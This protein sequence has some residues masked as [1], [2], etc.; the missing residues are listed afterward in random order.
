MLRDNQKTYPRCVVY[1]KMIIINQYDV[2]QQPKT[3]NRDHDNYTMNGKL[4]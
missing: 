3:D 2:L 4:H 1:I